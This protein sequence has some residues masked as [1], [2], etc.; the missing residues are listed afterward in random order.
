MR[1]FADLQ[2][3]LDRRTLPSVAFVKALGFRTEHP[4]SGTAITAGVDFV[5]GITRAVAASAYADS[6]L[7]LITYDESGGYF[8]HV[9]PPPT[10]AD[11][12]P[13]GARVPLLALGRFAR[14]GSVS[15][16]TME[17]A[18]IVKFIEW[19]WLGGRTG[20]LGTRDGSVN[21]LGSLLDARRTGAPVPER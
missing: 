21:N 13:Y 16:V 4:G 12:Q 10:A 20:Q 14:E 17:H 6:T 3:D 5:A 2:T 1:D 7:L 11:G 8:D 19:N 9:P 18:S 15:H